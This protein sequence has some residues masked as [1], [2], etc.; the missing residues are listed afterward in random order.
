MTTETFRKL[1]LAPS[2]VAGPLAVYP[3]IGSEPRL[4]YRSLAQA[5]KQGAFVTEVDE[6]GSVNEVLVCNASDQPVLLYEGAGTQ[7][8]RPLTSDTHRIRLIRSS[9][10]SSGRPRT[11][12]A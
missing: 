1:H 5:T 8:P 4:R 2:Q 12:G 10:A 3:I 7:C 11:S 6:R 9:G